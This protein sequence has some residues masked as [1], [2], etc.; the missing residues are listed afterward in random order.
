MPVCAPIRTS[1]GYRWATPRR[2]GLL[3]GDAGRG[4]SALEAK[5]A[6]QA[7]ATTLISMPPWAAHALRSPAV[8]LEHRG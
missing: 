6:K 5:A 3:G 2:R 1:V 7:S 4:A 8:L